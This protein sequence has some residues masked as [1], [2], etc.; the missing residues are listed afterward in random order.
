MPTF[1][2]WKLS[3][4]YTCVWRQ[5]LKM[6]WEAQE[7]FRL[8]SRH[9]PFGCAL[10]VCCWALCEPEHSKC[11]RSAQHHPRHRK[12][13]FARFYF[14]F[15][16]HID[17]KAL[18]QKVQGAT[19]CEKITR[20]FSAH[21]WELRNE[22]STCCKFFWNIYHRVGAWSKKESASILHSDS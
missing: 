9:W 7:V 8:G 22:T 1:D 18:T 13:M 5:Q 12:G 10:Q 6:W 19:A 2:G 20:V 14:P 17:F 15:C 4:S 3:H 16:L 11:L 21:L